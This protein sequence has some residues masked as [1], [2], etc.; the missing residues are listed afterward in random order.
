[1]QIL[2]Y[3]ANI[4]SQYIIAIFISDLYICNIVFTN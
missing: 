1:M 3:T 4:N 2:I